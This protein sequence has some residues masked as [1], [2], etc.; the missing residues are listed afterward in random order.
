[1]N[2]VRL[3]SSTAVIGIGVFSADSV[4]LDPRVVLESGE[5]QCFSST[6]SRR[7][8]ESSMFSTV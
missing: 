6:L 3:S 5:I 2:R 4:A 7:I 1:M 8:S